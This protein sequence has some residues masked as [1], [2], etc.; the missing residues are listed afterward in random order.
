MPNILVKIP[1]GAFPTEHRAVLVQKLNDAAAIA[2]QIPDDPRKRSMCWV[3]IDEVEPG[4]WTCGASDMSA[5]LLPCLAVIYVPAGV[6]DDASQAMYV[7][8][9]HA[10]FKQ[11]LPA[12]EKRQLA[13]S[14]I[15]HNVV[16][17]TWGVNDTIWRLPNFAQAAGYAHLQELVSLT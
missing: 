6:L 12:T 17:G 5:K 15:L 2:E 8:L 14:V 10:A 9:V 11:S 13:T 1:K 3:I 7:D 4:A 16:D